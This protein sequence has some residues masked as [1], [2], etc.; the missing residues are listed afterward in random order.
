MRSIALQPSKRPLFSQSLD[1]QR[2]AGL[3]NLLTAHL[4]QV[5]VEALK[6]PTR[7]RPASAVARQAAMYVCHVAL[8]LSFSE[9]GEIFERDRTTAAYA[10]RV[11][12]DRRDN[13][14]FDELIGRIEAAVWAL[15][16]RRRSFFLPI[17]FGG[18]IS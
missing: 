17:A 5:S 1:A 2:Q 18:A 13:Q 12:E 4:F 15:G 3:V 11:I 8:G 6:S 14:A 10:C 7:K 16:L 9:V